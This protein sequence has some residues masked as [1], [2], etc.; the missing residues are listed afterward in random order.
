MKPCCQN[1]LDNSAKPKRPR[2]GRFKERQSCPTCGTEFE[3]TFEEVA[4]LG[5]DGDSEYAVVGADP[6]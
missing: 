3:I 5:D 2:E 6:V 4:T 1:W